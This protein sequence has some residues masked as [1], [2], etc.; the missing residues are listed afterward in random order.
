MS[1]KNVKGVI[2]PR[3][4]TARNWAN[5]V[6]FIPRKGELIVYDADPEG[7][8][9]D[10]TTV[11]INGIAYPVEP[12]T[13]V[14]FKFGDGELVDEVMVGTNVNALPFATTNAE[15]GDIEVD[16]TYSPESSNAQSGKAVAEALAQFEPSIN[17]D[18]LVGQK[19]TEGGEIF[20]DYENNKAL[21]PYTSSFGN[22]TQ[23]GACGYHFTGLEYAED[24]K[25]AT[26]LVPKHYESE[27]TVYNVTSIGY[28]NGDI[29]NIDANSHQYEIFRITNIDST[30]SDAHRITFE[31]VKR[32]ETFG[33]N[34]YSWE[35]VDIDNNTLKLAS[36]SLT[37]NWVWCT[38][39]PNVGF[40][41][42][43]FIGNIS[44]GKSNKA[45]G[46]STV[47]LGRD[48]TAVGNHSTVFGRRNSAVGYVSLSTG[49][50]TIALGEQSTSIGK[51]TVAVGE[52]SL[53]MN[54]YSKTFADNS[55]AGGDSCITQEGADNS[56]A[57]GNG[58]YTYSPSSMAVGDHI[59]TRDNY[60]GQVAFGRFNR[61]T[62]SD[63]NIVDDTIFAIGNGSSDT[64]RCNAFEIKEDGRAYVNNGTEKLTTETD[65]DTILQPYKIGTFTSDGSILFS[66]TQGTV[67]DGGIGLGYQSTTTGVHSITFG[68][69]NSAT[70]RATVAGGEHCNATAIHTIALGL[71]NTAS[72]EDS[73]TIGS[74]LTSTAKN[75]TLIGHYPGSDIT[76][77]VSFAVGIG[78]GSVGTPTV[79]RTGLKIYKDGRTEIYKC[80][81][82][83]KSVVTKEYVDNKIVF[84]TELPE[85][86]EYADA[87]EG[88]IYF[89]YIE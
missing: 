34:K 23:A 57:F 89:Q 53:A 87:P 8:V 51:N 75:Q 24:L 70:G 4:D 44:A 56:I 83:P 26:I 15:G 36:D 65:V 46:Y 63:Y 18:Q 78:E 72:H 9:Y 84:G 81:D 31:Q 6:N 17:E 2:I 37:D 86:S 88:T 45:L 55:I 33:Y 28:V 29:V 42:P 7:T 74:K 30:S 52:R 47:A 11:T 61:R 62:I 60:M 67:K 40:P 16:L 27:G 3:H 64:N 19:T 21:T 80:G 25:T 35:V 49:F 59:Y 5:A 20:N 79:T 71:L 12:S 22:S 48:N 43:A 38:K 10:I 32:I 85:Q 76:S 68:M 73:V 39:K 54:Y 77:D 69:Y 1:T 82:T 50:E 66:G 41:I 14:R 58:S 13:K